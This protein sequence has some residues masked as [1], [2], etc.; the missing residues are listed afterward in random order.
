LNGVEA[1]DALLAIERYAGVKTV[2]LRKIRRQAPSL[3]RDV[4]ERKHIRMYRKAVESAAAGKL[5]D[6][7]ERLDTMG[8]IVACGIGEQADKFAVEYL[9]HPEQ[10]APAAVVSQ[11]TRDDGFRLV[12]AVSNSARGETL[13]R[14]A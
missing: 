7:Y 10:N 4:E 14:Y 9:R 1:S 13:R 12:L 5:D 2:E 8:A 3:G 6:S 11:I